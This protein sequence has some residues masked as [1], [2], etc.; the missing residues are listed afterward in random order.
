MSRCARGARSTSS[1]RRR[2][3]KSQLPLIEKA[4]AAETDA[5]AEGAAR[6]D[7]RA[8]LISSSDRAKRLAAAE[9]LGGEQPEHGRQPAAGAPRR[10][11]RDRRRGARRAAAVARRGAR[12]ARL[13]RA[14]RRHLHRR[15]P[16][17]GPAAGRARPGDHLRPDGRHQHGARRADDDRRLHDLRRAEPVPQPTCRAPSTPTSWS[18]SRRPSWS[19]RWSARCS[20]AACIRFLYGRPLETLLATWGISLVLQQAVRSIFGAQN[21]PVENPTLAVRRRRR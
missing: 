11:R 4:L 19:R 15:Q 14:P 16:R 10:R 21:V 3:T 17:L 18:R 20:S 9:A 2:S 5:G 1:A 7:A 6:A 12:P 8:I 13:G